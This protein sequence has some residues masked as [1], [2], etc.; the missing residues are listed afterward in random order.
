M[1]QLKFL[2]VGLGSIGERHVRNLLQLGQKDISVFRRSAREPRT[3]ESSKFN[4]F[5]S[6]QS[7]LGQEPDIVI[8]TNPTALHVPL[9]IDAAGNGS[10]LLI[11][12]PLSASMEGV[13]KLRNII[14]QNH[15]VS[16]MGHNLRFHPC[17]KKVKEIVESGTIGE[18]L[19]ARAEFGEY[20]PECHPWEDY[21][22]GYAARKELGGGAL[23]T[24]IH[25]VDYLY[26]LFGAVKKVSCVTKKLSN[27]EMDVEDTAVL[28]MEHE[29]G[30][31]SEVHLDFIQRTYNR[32]LQIIGSEGTLKW[33]FVTNKVSYFGTATDSWVEAFHM[34]EFDF[35][36]TYIDEIIHMIRCVQD[37]DTPLNDVNQGIDILKIGLAAHQSSTEARAIEIKGASL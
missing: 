9:A 17:L 30:I 2:I 22:Q 14:A 35:N 31:L 34:A 32:S 24:S 19:S 21:R 15:L 20:L 28:I 23:F 11:E 10:N 27:L 1:K 5:T 6:W 4:T 13:D 33:D 26:W 37:G 16:L 25:E 7:A 36:S 18:P 29:N 12:I 8:I 3:L